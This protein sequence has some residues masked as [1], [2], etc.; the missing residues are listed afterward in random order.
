MEG[1]K[2]VLVHVIADRFTDV[3]KEHIL[4]AKTAITAPR[5]DRQAY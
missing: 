5:S 2:D 1:L 4:P 3:G